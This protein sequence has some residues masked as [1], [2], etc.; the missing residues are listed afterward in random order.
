[1][2]KHISFRL[3]PWATHSVVPAWH[4]Q[5]SIP[6]TLILNRKRLA[7]S[8]RPDWLTD[9]M[10]ADTK[11][12]RAALIGYEAQLA[13]VR[14]AIHEIRHAL[15]SSD[16]VVQPGGKTVSDGRIST[17]GRNRIAQAQKRRWAAYRKQKRK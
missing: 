13:K 4:E 14:G 1:M 7:L 2:G 5:P 16:P 3:R 12:L 9:F 17:E 6:Q 10:T 8:F 11:L 15:A